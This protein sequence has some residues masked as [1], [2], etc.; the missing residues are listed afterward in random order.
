MARQDGKV[1]KGT[2][3]IVLENEYPTFAPWFFQDD[4]YSNR[5]FRGVFLMTS[6]TLMYAIASFDK[7]IAARDHSCVTLE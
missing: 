5:V 2:P 4:L 3:G 7:S 6:V 1:R